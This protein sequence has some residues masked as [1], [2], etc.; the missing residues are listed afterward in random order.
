MVSAEGAILGHPQAGCLQDVYADLSGNVLMHV[1]VPE[2]GLRSS[3]WS[4]ISW[5]SSQVHSQDFADAKYI[6]RCVL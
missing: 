3:H 1:T 5:A 4:V 2:L 6:Y